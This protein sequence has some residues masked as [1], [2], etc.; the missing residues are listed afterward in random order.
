MNLNEVLNRHT[1]S[2]QKENSFISLS[3]GSSSAIWPTIEKLSYRD[4]DLLRTI[5]LELT[6]ES[7]SS[8]SVEQF[9]I[10]HIDLNLANLL[11]NSFTNKYDRSTELGFSNRKKMQKLFK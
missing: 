1:K 8:D 10:D 4:L 2:L 9:L 7:A 3:S 11:D 6:L 5:H